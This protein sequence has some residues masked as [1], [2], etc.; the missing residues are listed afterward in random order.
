MADCGCFKPHSQPPS[1]LDTCIFVVW[2]FSVISLQAIKWTYDYC[3]LK[4][5][6]IYTLGLC[7]YMCIIA[8]FLEDALWEIFFIVR[9]H[10]V[11]NNG[12]YDAT[13][14][15]SA[16]SV[17][18][19]RRFIADWWGSDYQTGAPIISTCSGWPETMT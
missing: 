2:P 18:K 15:K 3:A 7:V 5:S 6:S 11:F 14:N 1:C 9:G 4:M 12:T 13:C 17:Q 19:A 10:F 8:I 16:V